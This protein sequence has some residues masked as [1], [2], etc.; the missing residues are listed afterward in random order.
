MFTLPRRRDGFRLLLPD[1][2]IVPE[3]NEK[4]TPILQ[5]TRGY[6]AKPIDFINETI[7]KVQVFGFN[8]AAFEQQQPTS[9]R[10]I[11]VKWREEEN[12]MLTGGST[13][14]YRNPVSPI[15]LTDKTLNIEFR[16]TLGYLNYFILMENF[17]YLYS[18]DTPSI[19]LPK[20]IYL[21]IFNQK[22]EVYA[23]IDLIDPVINGM[24]ML[25]FDYTQPIAQSE[26]FKM[27]LKYSNFDYVFIT[28]EDSINSVATVN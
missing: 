12:A 22:G 4:Y 20:H 9:G 1:E 21:D 8:N 26:T 18:K 17:I 16:H 6:I 24:D 3:I 28:E 14:Q 25:D 23:R 19:T 13:F 11:R 2:F 10:P 5:K 15:A 7:Q 27:E